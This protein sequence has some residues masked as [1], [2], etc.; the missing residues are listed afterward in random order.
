MISANQSYLNNKNL[1]FSSNSQ[2]YYTYN[3]YHSNNNNNNNKTTTIKVA[4]RLRP[5]LPHEDFEYWVIDPINNL[6]KT[7][8]DSNY[9]KYYKKDKNNSFFHDPNNINQLLLD[10]IYIPQSFKFDKIFT[11]EATSEKIYLDM[12]QDIIKGFLNGINGTIFTYGQT[13]SGKTYTMLGNVDYP[14]ILPC[15]LKNLFDLLEMKKK[16]INFNYNLYC[17]YVEIYNEI[18]HDLIGDSTGC[19]IVE[20]NNYGLIVSDAQRVCINSFEE[21]VQ[22]KDLGEEK[23]QYKNT[24][25][26][27]Y[28]SR[29]HTIFQLFLE[30]STQDNDSNTVYKKYSL[31]NLVDLAGSERVN[32]DENNNTN[33]E[34]GYI[35]KSLF[36]LANVINKLS[37]NKNIHIPYR[38]SKLTRLLSVA[39]GGGSLVNI[40]CNISPSASNYFQ[41]VSTL[42]FANRA[43]NIKIKPA[44]NEKIIRKYNE[45]HRTINFYNTSNNYYIN[46]NN[47]INQRNK[48]D[49]F[50][51][52][53]DDTSN[54]NLES[55]NYNGTIDYQRKYY[56]LLLKNKELISENN[57]LKSTVENFMELNKSNNNSEMNFIDKCIEK[58]KFLILKT[59]NSKEINQYIN[60]NLKELKMNYINQLKSIQ[61][62]YLSKINELQNAIMTNLSNNTKD[63]EKSNNETDNE[64]NFELFSEVDLDF[65]H[66]NDI[67]DVKLIYE[68]KEQQL[69][70]LMTKYKEST[71]LYFVNLLKNSNDKKN[72]SELYK[73]RMSELENLYEKAQNQLEKNF[74]KKLREITDFI[75]QN[76]H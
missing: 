73:E 75:K 5:L 51:D 67:K 59:N 70:Q 58:I 41:T 42:R 36:A 64:N 48:S 29:S 28:S 21:G 20:D 74:F 35:N 40:I 44:I 69:E 12:C 62:L 15:S 19:K 55:I 27:E 22:L 4:I 45:K 30:T 9:N 49:L 16:E 76:N 8:F 31:L 54:N 53:E 37:E 2:S 68:N 32:K 13:T 57:K 6:I 46:R 18:I 1:S 7:S 10:N 66:V 33:N 47:L 52:Y 72:I 61:N 23:R 56:E 24:I 43:K 26:N 39:L 60:N 14:G 38:D 3:N 63:N 65:G 71:D 50:K 34:T 17:S 11:K 25:I